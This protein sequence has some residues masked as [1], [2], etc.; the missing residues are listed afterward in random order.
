MDTSG[1]LYGKPNIY[2]TIIIPDYRLKAGI[3]ILMIIKIIIIIISIIS[4]FLVT[5]LSVFKNDLGG[6]NLKHI[7]NRRYDYSFEFNKVLMEKKK[8]YSFLNSITSN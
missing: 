7:C 5:K 2:E 3:S 6:F 4:A 8:I 1:S